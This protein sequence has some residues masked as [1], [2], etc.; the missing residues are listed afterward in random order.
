MN[1]W[2]LQMRHRLGGSTDAIACYVFVCILLCWGDV[3]L[4]EAT[5]DASKDKIERTRAS[6]IR[7]GAR[8]VT[9]VLANHLSS[10]IIL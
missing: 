9:A 7:G 4:L 8:R 1:L 2:F 6:D 10:F 3:G 5:L